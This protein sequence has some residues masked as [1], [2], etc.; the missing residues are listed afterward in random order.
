MNLSRDSISDFALKNATY[1]IFAAILLY[2]GL[3]SSH[4]LSAESLGNIVKQG[5]FI[6]IV[7]IG[8]TFVLLIA[9][10]DLSVGSVIYLAPLV[11]GLAIQ[12]FGIPPV[13]GLFV[14]LAM[15]L[16]LG[17]INAFLVVKLRI[18]PF[19]VTLATL[20]FFRG[21]GVWLTDSVP[22]DFEQS[23]LEFGSTRILGVP[24]PICVLAVVAAV[25][26]LLLA[27]TGFGRQVY[28]V[29]NNLES[30]R[31]AGLDVDWIRARCYIICSGCAAIAGYIW[32]AQIGRLDAGFGESKEFDVIA[33]A[34]LGGVSLFGGAGTA[35][36]AVIGALLI[37]TV[38]A[39]LSF[40]GVNLYAQPIVQGMIIFFAVF[41][42]GIRGKRVA[43][44]LKRTIRPLNSTP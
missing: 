24:L 34:V 28:A 33:A 5:S 17:A 30:A 42:D 2:F 12:Q 16:L 18:V 19:V 44:L 26:H 15:G 39:G 3:Q 41:V 6:G 29:G 10:I 7:A 32:I 37:Q 1:L 25:A 4:F 31:K 13:L 22:F 20:F 27:Y 40:T 21:F 11:A 38:T 9:G 36:G 35:I 43:A 8:M 14:A 23:F